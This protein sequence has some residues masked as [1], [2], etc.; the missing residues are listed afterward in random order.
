MSQPEILGDNLQAVPLPAI[1]KRTGPRWQIRTRVEVDGATS[2]VGTVVWLKRRATYVFRSAISAVLPE[3][4]LDDIA[5]F[6]RKVNR[7]HRESA[8]TPKRAP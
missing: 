5:A 1:T 7:A 3:D 4:Y 2:R 8:M 6:L